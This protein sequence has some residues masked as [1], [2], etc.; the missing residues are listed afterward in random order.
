MNIRI[1]QKL[2]NLGNALKQLESALE[3]DIDKKKLVI[4]G[5][6][7]RFEFCYEL[8]WKTLKVSLEQEGIETTTPKEA[9]QEA[10][11]A[12]WLTDEKIWLEMIKDRNTTSHVYNEETAVAIYQHIKKKYYPAIKELYEK[13]VGLADKPNE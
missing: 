7:Q 9:F 10:Y 12:K 6:I 4:D 1:Q 5:T 11:R 13:I 2:T 8:C 3:E